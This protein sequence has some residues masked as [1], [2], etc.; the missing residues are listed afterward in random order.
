MAAGQR[1]TMQQDGELVGAEGEK[2]LDDMETSGKL[3]KKHIGL[4]QTPKSE[5][6]QRQRQP[7]PWEPKSLSQF[8]TLLGFWGA[9]GCRKSLTP[10][11]TPLTSRSTNI[12]SALTGVRSFCK[13]P[14]CPL[15][16]G[17]CLI[18]IK[19]RLCSL[20]LGLFIWK[21]KVPN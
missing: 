12:A 4:D 6:H 16:T 7:I 19:C 15:F 5:I 17:L 10:E 11:E 1:Q 3:R 13:H 21:L 20:G 9:L 2:V 8:P 14:P 18:G